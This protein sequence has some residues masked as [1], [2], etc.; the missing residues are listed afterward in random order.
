MEKLKTEMP[1]VIEDYSVS[2]TTLEQVFLSFAK[3][4]RPESDKD[5]EVA[6]EEGKNELSPMTTSEE[7]E[8]SEPEI[9]ISRL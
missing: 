4:Q 1:A 5:R 8:D 2:E 7:E 9:Q 6:E 3:N